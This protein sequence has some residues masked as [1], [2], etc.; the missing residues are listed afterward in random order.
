MVSE[1]QHE[2]Q[3]H[4]NE[5][6]LSDDESKG[7]QDVNC[8]TDIEV[9]KPVKLDTHSSTQNNDLRQSIFHD[10]QQPPLESMQRDDPGSKWQ[11]MAQKDDTSCSRKYPAEKYISENMDGCFKHHMR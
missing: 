6:M 9:R 8:Q 11:S 4:I 5:S 7:L 10:K 1:M 2:T 3:P